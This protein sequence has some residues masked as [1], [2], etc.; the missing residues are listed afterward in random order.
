MDYLKT[1]GFKI[2]D[3]D[4]I[5]EDYSDFFHTTTY[6]HSNLITTKTETKLKPKGFSVLYYS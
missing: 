1:Y 3:L 6:F 5:A 4:I 2:K